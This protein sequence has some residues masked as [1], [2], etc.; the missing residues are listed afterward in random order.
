MN[1]LR[2][3]AFLIITIMLV[4]TGVSAHCKG[5]HTGD[6]PH[7]DIGGEDPPTNSVLFTGD[8]CLGSSGDFPALAFFEK[9]YGTTII[10]RGRNKGDTVTTEVGHDIYLA[11]TDGSCRLLIFSNN[12]TGAI[13]VSVRVDG[14]GNYKLIWEQ[15][16]SIPMLEFHVDAKVITTAAPLTETSAFTHASANVEFATLNKNGS[17]A[18]FILG[19]NGTSTINSVATSGGAYVQLASYSDTFASDIDINP[20]EDV[21]YYQ[22]RSNSPDIVTISFM[23]SDDSG[24]WSS[25]GV[26]IDSSTPGFSGSGH[27]SAGLWDHDGN[28]SV[29]EVLAFSHQ[30]QIDILDVSGCTTGSSVPCITTGNRLLTLP[31]NAL[32]PGFTPDPDGIATRLLI[33][34]TGPGGGEHLDVAEFDLDSFVTTVLFQG[35]RPDAVR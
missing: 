6:H 20:A 2:L 28:G 27:L 33:D 34:L 4:P 8:A 3:S 9:R 7:C 13:N 19:E 5:K 10:P 30:E 15:G 26:I 18:Y 35:K 11:N 21:L 14:Q 16:T 23:Q 12:M 22:T 25:P 29:S 32:H 17:T 31:I 24:N 1:I